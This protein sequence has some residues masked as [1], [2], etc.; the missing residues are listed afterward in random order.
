MPTTWKLKDYLKQHGVT[1]YAL[2]I[3]TEGKLSRNTIYSLVR[4]RPQRLQLKTLDVLI[5]ALTELTGEPVSVTDLLAYEPAPHEQRDSSVV[6]SERE[7]ELAALLE[8]AGPLKLAVGRG[9]PRGSAVR[10]ARGASVAEAVVEERDE[11]A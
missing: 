7:R 11:R 1:P 2:S 3:K 8:A 4:E 9:K 10:I 6:R 5:P